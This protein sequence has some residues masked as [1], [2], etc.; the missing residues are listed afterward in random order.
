VRPASQLWYCS[1]F[2][3][4]GTDY[5]TH[6]DDSH[7]DVHCVRVDDVASIA[8]LTYYAAKLLKILRA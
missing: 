1:P 2:P 7:G 3:A 6:H 8:K 4:A 5:L